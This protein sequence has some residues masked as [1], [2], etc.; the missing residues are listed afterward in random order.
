MRGERNEKKSNPLNTIKLTNTLSNEDIAGTQARAG[1]PVAI[2]DSYVKPPKLYRYRS[3]AEFD[4][5]VEAIERGYLFCAVFT[6]LNDPMEG[7]FS[8]SRHLRESDGYRTIRNAILENKS[9]LG[10]CSFS[11]VRNHELMWAH[12]AHQFSGIC[13]AY[14]FSKLLKCL[15]EDI[16][17]VRMFYNETEPTIHRTRKEPSNLA[18]MVLSYKNYRWLYEREWRMF[19][20]QG[21]A[22][23][24][25]TSCVTDVYLGS[26]ISDAHREETTNRLK[27]LKI[28]LRN[29]TIKKYSISFE[30]SS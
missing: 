18:K 21:R 22:Y 10:M 20:P 25:N 8:S 17:F 16:S 11:E 26:R 1:E 29:M 7:L 6:T 2:I 23:Y 15:P 9:Q 24:R 30:T 28:K 5:E 14:S 12:Y 4:R 19:A 13:I 27:P 3:L